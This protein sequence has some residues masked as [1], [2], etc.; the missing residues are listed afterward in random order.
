MKTTL[1]RSWKLVGTLA[2]VSLLVI[3]FRGPER[4]ASAAEEDPPATTPPSPPE[5]IPTPPPEPPEAEAP[6]AAAVLDAPLSAPAAEIVRLAQAGVS[7]DVMLAFIANSTALFN[8]SSSQVIYLNDLGLS[9]A[10]IGAMIQHDLTLKAGPGTGNPVAPPLPVV[11][12]P[13]TAPETSL[14]PPPPPPTPLIPENAIYNPNDSTTTAGYTTGAED[15]PLVEDSSG[16]FHDA[17]SPYGNWMYVDGYGWC[18]QPTVEVV[19]PDWQPYGDR[20]RWID[21]D[22]GWYWHSDYSWGWAAFHYGRWF[23]HPRSG[24]VWRPDRVWGPAWVSWRRSTDY[25]GWA[26]LPPWAR[27]APGVGF[28]HGNR[29]V[30]EGFEF[31][32]S[33]RHYTFIPIERMT[34]YTPYRYRAAPGQVGRVFEESAVINHYT[35]R[36]DRVINHG[37]DPV[38]VAQLAHIERHPAVVRETAGPGKGNRWEQVEKTGGKIIISRPQLPAT[39]NPP[40]VRPPPPVRAAV[41]AAT[42]AVNSSPRTEVHVANARPAPFSPAV[43]RFTAPPSGEVRPTPPPITP[44]AQTFQTP[45]ASETRATTVG[46]KPASPRT[47][48]VPPANRPFPNMNLANQPSRPA[49]VSETAAVG[50]STKTSP[51]VPPPTRGTGWEAFQGQRAPAPGQTATTP[52]HVAAFSYEDRPGTSLTRPTTPVAPTVAGPGANPAQPQGGIPVFGR[53]RTLGEVGANPAPAVPHYGS[54]VANQNL[55]ERH[56]EPANHTPAP[57]PTAPHLP[58]PPTIVHQSPPP[59]SPPVQHTPPPAPAPAPAANNKPK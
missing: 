3:S 39:G 12:L 55:P 42:V 33:A 46:S 56:F 37:I 45:A 23:S 15:G 57:A 13:V 50:T 43:P 24:W 51:T 35:V 52:P 1:L 10:V 28:R 22:C 34:D 20:G 38:H 32:L 44:V 9:G 5:S 25:C 47:G 8:L 49:G 27:F 58:P 16:Y 14:A 40:P 7:S 59:A 54:P 11:P 30:G 41:P 26:P 21:S 2:V 36:G 17:L 29:V 53:P 4:S 6:R 31:G 18:W 19:N 48:G